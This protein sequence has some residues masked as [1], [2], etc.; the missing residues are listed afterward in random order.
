MAVAAWVG[1][2]LCEDAA[3]CV[4]ETKSLVWVAIDAPFASSAGGATAE[5]DDDGGGEG[6]LAAV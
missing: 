3:L 4:G 6:N 5:G 2:T 1:F